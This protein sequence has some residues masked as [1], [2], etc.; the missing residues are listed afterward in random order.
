MRGF[1]NRKIKTDENIIYEQIFEGMKAK[2]IY[3][4][5]LLNP[6]RF[7]YGMVRRIKRYDVDC[8]HPSV[9]AYKEE[10]KIFNACWEGLEMVREYEHKL[11][12]SNN[13]FQYLRDLCG[14]PYYRIV[15]DAQKEAKGVLVFS[16]KKGDIKD[17]HDNGVPFLHV[18]RV[19]KKSL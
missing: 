9:L 3:S 16:N 7:Y 12:I 17:K 13:Y 19:F 15:Y 5:D 6:V 18:L 10:R 11:G 1:R 8:A 4:L 2:G 14:S